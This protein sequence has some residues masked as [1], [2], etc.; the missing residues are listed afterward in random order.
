MSPRMERKYQSALSDA[1]PAW[2]KPNQN[3]ILLLS[4]CP[5]RNQQSSEQTVDIFRA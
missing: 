4:K 2:V 5:Q 3:E 1:A